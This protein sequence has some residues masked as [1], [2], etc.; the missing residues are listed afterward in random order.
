MED[1]LLA[2]VKALLERGRHRGFVT[3]DELNLAMPQEHFTAEQIEDTMA[4]LWEMGIHV[5]EGGGGDDDDPVGTP[6]Y[7]PQGPPPLRGEAEPER[8]LEST[9]ATGS[10]LG[11]LGPT[12]RMG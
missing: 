3:Y 9:K 2:G 4:S 5:V 7:G 8:P 11:V 12:R 10:S 6:P 1:H